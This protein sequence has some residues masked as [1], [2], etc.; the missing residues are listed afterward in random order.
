MTATPHITAVLLA[1]AP[2]YPSCK[3][4]IMHLVTVHIGEETRTTL[5]RQPYALVFGMI[6]PWV[7]TAVFKD[8]TKPGTP[9]PPHSVVITPESPAWSG[10]GFTSGKIAFGP[11]DLFMP[12]I[13]SD[14]VQNMRQAGVLDTSKDAQL[15]RKFTRLFAMYGHKIIRR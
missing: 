10:S 9:I 7:I 8:C 12:Q 11:R 13:R 1:I 6:G 2:I 5:R 14:F 3:E 4:G 15:D